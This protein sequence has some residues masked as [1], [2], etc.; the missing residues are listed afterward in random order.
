MRV[1]ASLILL[2]SSPSVENRPPLFRIGS[3]LLLATLD[4]IWF[5][6]R[7][8]DEEVSIFVSA[9]FLGGTV[10][11]VRVQGP[12]GNKGEFR[13]DGWMPLDYVFLHCMSLQ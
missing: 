8:A 9:R 6:S 1:Y 11:A 2:D 12:L 10:F 5:A 4:A 3:C 13:Q 7:E